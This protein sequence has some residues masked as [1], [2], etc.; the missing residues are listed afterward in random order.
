[1]RK[2]CDHRGIG[3][4]RVKDALF[5]PLF[6]RQGRL[7]WR[8]EIDSVDKLLGI[9]SSGRGILREHLLDFIDMWENTFK[10][11]DKLWGILG[12]VGPM[13]EECDAEIFSAILKFILKANSIISINN[14][15]DILYYGGF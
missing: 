9:L 15:F 7:R 8:N 11:K 6:S 5:D 3:F 12:L 13:R 14:L 2:C 1:M 10:E 4:N